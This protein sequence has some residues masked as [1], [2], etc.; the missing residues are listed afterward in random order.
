MFLLTIVLISLFALNAKNTAYS[1]VNF[2]IVGKMLTFKV[3]GQHYKVSFH[4]Y[5]S[6]IQNSKYPTIILE[7]GG[8]GNLIGFLPLL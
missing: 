5:C 7:H 8:G 1:K 3:E 6:K 2:P 4:Y